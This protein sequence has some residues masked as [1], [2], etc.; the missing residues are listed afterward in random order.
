MVKST[1]PTLTNQQRAA[2]IVTRLHAAYPDAQCSL[3]FSTP[4]QLLVATILSAQCTDERVN[5]VTP[6]LF[7]QYPTVE[8]FATAPIEELEQVIKSTGF[9]HNKARNIQNMSRMLLAEYEGEVPHTM[10]AL[11]RLPG[12]ARKT[13][14]VVLGNAMNTIDGVVVDTHVSRLSQRLNLST[15]T[16]P[17]KIERD[18]MAIVEHADWVLFSHLLINHGRAICKAQKPNCA[19]CVLVD[20]CPFGQEHTQNK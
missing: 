17:E 5:M 19:S 12:V 8:A 11:V 1:L 4:F 20:L 6:I 16:D 3:S 10:A 7:A 18:L 13:A 9:Y 2:E 15:N 14:N